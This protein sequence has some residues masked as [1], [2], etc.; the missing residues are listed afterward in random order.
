VLAICGRNSS[1]GFLVNELV[2]PAESL[3]IPL[4]ARVGSPWT[5]FFIGFLVYELVIPGRITIYPWRASV[6]SPRTKNLPDGNKFRV[7]AVRGRNSSDGF[8]VYELI[9]PGRITI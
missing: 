7:L 5:K 2:F 9:I 6:G 8:L 4:K 3:F 1:D